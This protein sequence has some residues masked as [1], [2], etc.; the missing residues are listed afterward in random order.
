MWKPELALTKQQ[1]G[2][3]VLPGVGFRANG[4]KRFVTGRGYHR[5]TVTANPAKESLADSAATDNRG[6]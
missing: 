6:R 5:V 4:F 3:T 1:L 2:L